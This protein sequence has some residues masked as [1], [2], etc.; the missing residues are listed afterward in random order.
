MKLKGKRRIQKR[1]F[2][3][4]FVLSYVIFSFGRQFYRIHQLNAEIDGYENHKMAL[5]QEEKL[6]QEE[7]TLL[8]N[9]AYIERIAREELGL[10][11][12]G[13]TLLVPG[14]VDDVKAAVSL[15]EVSDNIH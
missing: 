11:K 14:K 2:V 13:E 5:L 12:P 4:L 9:Q 6:L 1:F 15:Q 10:I 3:F 8:N 7:I